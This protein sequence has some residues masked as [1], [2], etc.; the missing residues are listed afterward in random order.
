M[1]L[2]AGLTECGNSENNPNTE[3]EPVQVT[4]RVTPDE[5]RLSD[6]NDAE[7]VLYS[8]HSWTVASNQSWCTVTPTSGKDG[9]IKIGIYAASNVTESE[10]SAEITFTAEGSSVKL[11]VVQD[12][13]KVASYVPE[14]YAMV[15]NDEFNSGK[16]PDL[17]KWGYETGDHGWGNN[18]LQNYVAG[19]SGTDT[20]ALVSG[21]VLKIIAR[22]KG[23]QVISIRMNTKQSWTYGYFEARLK[24][25]AG[26]G[27]WPA[28]WMLPQNFQN[29]P[30]DGEID[31]M[32]EVGYRPNYVSA[33]IHCKSY[34]HVN[35]TQRTGE[36]L[37]PTAQSD[38]H[39]YALEWTADNIYAYVDGER[40]FTFAND[41]QGNKNT[42]PFNVPFYL[43]L[44]LAWGGN[45]GGAQGV[46]ETA[47]PATY[48]IDYVR[49]YQKN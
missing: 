24:L 16:M 25:P 1:F 41:R 5:L 21:G 20:C 22:K 28:F 49:V 42:W 36:K 14:G 31:I 32:E 11:T 30:D 44:N 39:V 10:R 48:E 12:A 26:K 45:W 23:S 3:P 19:V 47:L 4:I 15:W 27:T 37:I 9:S 2:L 40:Y 6:K 43:K 33:A 38:F 35:Q 34:N 18:E 17:N 13:T 7:V 8:T 46:D 29:W